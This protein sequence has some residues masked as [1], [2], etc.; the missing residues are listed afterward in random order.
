[1]KAALLRCGLCFVFWT[2]GSLFNS[3][4]A[5][6][7][8][9]DQ[10][11]QIVDILQSDHAIR[12]YLGGVTAFDAVLGLGSKDMLAKAP[13]IIQ[14]AVLANMTADDVTQAL[15]F[16]ASPAAQ[17]QT[18]IIDTLN[19]LM[20]KYYVPPPGQPRPEQNPGQRIP[21]QTDLYVMMIKK[22]IPP[23]DHSNIDMLIK[24][25]SPV[26]AAYPDEF[27]QLYSTY[28]DLLPPIHAFIQSRAGQAYESARSAAITSLVQ[29]REQLQTGHNGK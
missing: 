16:K 28:H 6:T 18:N 23:S 5:A 14:R 25:A 19:N 4:L 27:A 17:A 13:D 26:L 10:L 3:V 12:P 2:C 21:E 11:H 29:E 24:Q 8:T 9:Q 1:M 22:V 20:S 15:A 7:P